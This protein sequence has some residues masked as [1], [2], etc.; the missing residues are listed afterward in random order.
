MIMK[1]YAISKKKNITV[2]IIT[3]QTEVWFIHKSGPRDRSNRF[4]VST[5][6]SPMK[7]IYLYCYT[8]Y[9]YYLRQ[10]NNNIIKVFIR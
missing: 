2:K 7:E 1:R 10:R 5:T 8:G 3:N 6:L 9:Y 4:I